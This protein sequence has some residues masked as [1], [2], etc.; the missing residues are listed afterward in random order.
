MYFSE[1]LTGP[2]ANAY[3]EFN[4]TCEMHTWKGKTPIEK[5]F[6]DRCEA[7]GSTNFLS[8]IN[9]FVEIKN[10]GVKESDFPTG[11]LCISDGEFNPADLNTTNV[12]KARQLLRN[13]G[14]SKEYVDN[15]V[16]ILWDIPNDYYYNNCKPKFETFGNVTNV[17]YMSGYSASI[18]SFLSDRIATPR[19]LFEAAMNQETLNIFDEII[20]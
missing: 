17:F 15:F 5:W 12:S 3:M 10:S 20:K 14:F 6:N 13:A 11:I 4:T 7:Y 9:K 16:I 2:F 19:E 1:F 18:V 8:V